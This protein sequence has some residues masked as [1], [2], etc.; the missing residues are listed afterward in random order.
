MV[1]ER[2][3]AHGGNSL[4]LRRVI[5]TIHLWAGLVAALFLFGLGVSG[6]LVAFENEIDRALNPKLT[7]ITAGS[8][9]LTLAEMTAKLKAA[10][11][12][13]DVAGM[14]MS[15]RDDVAW[16]AFLENDT[17]EHS[18][19]FNPY[20]GAILG[21]K[22][23]HNNFTGEV[24]Q[25]HLHLLAGKTGGNIVT[26]AAVF[27]LVMA[28]SGLV[29][30]WPR[31]LLTVSWRK[32]WTKLNLEV[33]QVLGLYTSIFLM[34]FALTAIVIHWDG[35]VNRIAGAQGEPAWPHSKPVPPGR[36]TPDFD[37]ILAAAQS[38]EP[39]ARV[40]AISMDS[41][42]VRVAMKHPNDHTP[43]G[44]TNLFIDAYTRKID[45]ITDWRT[46]SPG[47]RWAK[48]WNREIHTGDIGGLPTRILACVISLSLPLMTITGPLIWWNRQRKRAPSTRASQ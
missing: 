25:F 33:H 46:G 13:F 10:Y 41:T 21:D 37:A 6:S 45:L 20:T 3:T 14:G 23:A 27:L 32:P 19:A 43:A 38:A 26:A 36:P 1:R 5:L 4:I 15:D 30:W 31:K 18:I 24:H 48:L 42:P 9:Q 44:R 11:P 40:T 35:L 22:S 29:L 17:A 47:L 34:F 28:I 39:D 2:L 7:W 12:G 16:S 8:H